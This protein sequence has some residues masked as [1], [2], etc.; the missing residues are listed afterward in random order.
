M[1]ITPDVVLLYRNV[2]AVLGFLFVFPYEKSLRIFP[3][4]SVKYCVGLLM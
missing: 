2:L 4:R 3:S 1:V